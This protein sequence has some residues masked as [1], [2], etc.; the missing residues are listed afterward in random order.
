MGKSSGSQTV[1]NKTE[2]PKWVQE[3]GQ[4]NLGAAYQVSANM[5]GPYSG[6][7]VADFVPGQL[8]NFNTLQNNV[9]ST[10]P[11]YAYA[12]A[13]TANAAGYNPMQVSPGYLSGMDLSSY[14]NPYTQSVIASGLGALDQQRQMALNQIGD[15]AIKTG[16]FAG[17]RQGVAEALTNAQSGMQ[18]GQLASQLMG[19]NFNQAQAAA[20][21][22]LSR[23]YQ[24]QLANQQAGLQ[25]VATNLQ[26]A[27]Q[28]GNL[29]SQGQQS[30]LQGLAAAQ[31]GQDAI[32]SQNQ[33]VLDAQKQY[34]TDQQQFPLQQLQIPI[35]ALGMTPYGNT[36]TQ[37]QPT[38]GS[39]FLTGLGGI[40]SGL[41]ILQGLAALSDRTMKT[42]IKK[43]GKDAETGLNLYA[44]RYKGDPKTYPKMV[45]PMAQ[46]VEKKYPD[47]VVEVNGKKMVNLGFG[48]MRRAFT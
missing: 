29:A 45:G 26:A 8:Q 42:D 17:S 44:Y 10:N 48:P 41:G 3:A 28:L 14:M 1:T 7:R 13:A 18:A 22:D 47:Q 33:N 20:Q 6:Q 15:Q 27:G 35:Q 23:N 39:G 40:S 25:G 37:T 31:A 5:L 30:F 38:S 19:Q 2:L 24:A 11:A 12:Q 9:G 34:Y 46:E 32:Q 4:K 43:V 16:A 36:Q 21:N